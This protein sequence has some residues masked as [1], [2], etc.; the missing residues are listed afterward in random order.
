VP[1]NVGTTHDVT[2]RSQNLLGLE[3]PSATLQDLGIKPS[4]SAK[5]SSSGKKSSSAKS[6]SKDKSGSSANGGKK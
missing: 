1:G 5:P 2:T 3:Y 4:S 6:G